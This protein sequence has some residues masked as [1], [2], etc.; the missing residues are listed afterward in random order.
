MH[1]TI[2][3]MLHDALMH[4]GTYKLARQVDPSIRKILGLNVAADH[5][6]HTMMTR[7]RCGCC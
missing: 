1:D 7:A 3:C 6:Q 4:D 2:G 5:G